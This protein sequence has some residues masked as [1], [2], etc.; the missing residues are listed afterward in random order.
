MEDKEKITLEEQ[1]YD[2]NYFKFFDVPIVYTPSF[3]EVFGEECE[4]VIGV[5][6]LKIRETYP[7]R[8]YDYLQVFHYKDIEYWCISDAHQYERLKDEHITFL[9]PKD[10]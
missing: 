5:S 9:L 3:Q 1:E 4:L 6:L 8:N 10:Y 7:K 2:N